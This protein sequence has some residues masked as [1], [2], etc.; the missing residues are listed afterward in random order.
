MEYPVR[1]RKKMKEKVSLFKLF[2]KEVV[3]TRQEG[4]G[5][6][7]YTGEQ[8]EVVSSLLKTGGG[9]FYID[10]THLEISPSLTLI[11]TYQFVS[12]NIIV[13]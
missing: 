7:T 11:N 4:G 2:T 8:S 12:S 1:S 5:L 3:C 6:N 10:L 13:S 9:L